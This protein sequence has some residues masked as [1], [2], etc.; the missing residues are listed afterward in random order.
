VFDEGA[1]RCAR[2][3]GRL[4]YEKIRLLRAPRL[5]G[6]RGSDRPLLY[7]I[8]DIIICRGRLDGGLSDADF[9]SREGGVK[10]TPRGAILSPSVLY[11]GLLLRK[12]NKS[13]Y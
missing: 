8:K 3:K 11:S 1:I 10:K 7:V 9:S 2:Q 4:A 6:E 13:A 12:G 5:H